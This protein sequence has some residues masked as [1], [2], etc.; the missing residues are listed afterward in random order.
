MVEDESIQWAIV[1]D[2]LFNK[3]SLIVRNNTRK[4]LYLDK[5][6]SFSYLNRKPKCLFSNSAQ[7]KGSTSSKGAS[8][9]LGAVAGVMGIGGAVGNLLSGVNVGGNRGVED[10]IFYYEQRILALAPQAAYIIEEWSDFKGY[11]QAALP[12]SILRKACI[13]ISAIRTRPWHYG[14]WLTT[15]LHSCENSV[16][17]AVDNYV[18]RI[19]IDSYRGL[20]SRDLKKTLYCRIPRDCLSSAIGLDLAKELGF[21]LLCQPGMA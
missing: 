8:V 14:A 1:L 15:T 3:A 10:A 19:V 7:E 2:S 4:V 13:G 12:K 5:A 6:N 9:K 17:L 18:E 16:Q 21:Y 20:K 11:L